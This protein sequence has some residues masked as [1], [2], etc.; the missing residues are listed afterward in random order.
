ML[1]GVEVYG[2]RG[3]GV[4]W[5]GWRCVEG[6]EECG[7]GRGVWKV[8]VCGRAEECGGRSGRMWWEG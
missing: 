7:R 3:R 8:E 4:W 6:V 5:E 2:V 1:E